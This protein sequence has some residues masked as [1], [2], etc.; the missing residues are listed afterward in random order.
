MAHRR[1]SRGV[2]TPTADPPR[3]APPPVRLVAMSDAERREAL[4]WEAVDY[5]EAKARAGIWAREGSL[6]RARDEIASLLGTD[7]RERGHAFFVGVDE[8]GRRVGWVWYGPVP[9][10]APPPGTRWLFQI[11]V[12]GNLRGRGYGRGLLSA[13]EQRLV[14]EGASELRL[15][16]FRWNT[17]A[18]ALY[19][20]SGYGVV[21]QGPGSLEMGK[22]LTRG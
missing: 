22:R 4:E 21:A 12:E 2:G 13:L 16:V 18:V 5:A 20:S 1:V 14:D 19:S 3:R 9:G 17:S 6:D 15:N 10:P 11:V 8:T 7:F